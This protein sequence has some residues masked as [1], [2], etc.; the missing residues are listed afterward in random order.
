M[1]FFFLFSCT[2]HTALG[3][4]IKGNHIEYVIPYHSIRSID[5]CYW[6][7]NCVDARL[8]CIYMRN[9]IRERASERKGRYRWFHS[10]S[11]CFFFSSSVFRFLDHLTS[12]LDRLTACPNELLFYVRPPLLREDRKNA[13]IDGLQSIKLAQRKDH[14]RPTRTRRRCRRRHHHRRR[15]RHC[16]CHMQSTRFQNVITVIIIVDNNSL[17]F[18]ACG[19]LSHLNVELVSRQR[20][21]WRKFQRNDS[22]LYLSFLVYY[23][24]YEIFSAAAIHRVNRMHTNFS[25]LYKHSHSCRHWIDRV[26]RH[27]VGES[28]CFTVLRSIGD[29]S[30]MITLNFPITIIIADV[31]E[32]GGNS[33]CTTSTRWHRQKGNRDTTILFNADEMEVNH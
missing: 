19:C 20:M 21:K 10:N 15:R 1:Y 22:V 11:L 8:F 31:G 28:M 14:D 7:R 9:S 30:L 2:D 3:A 29:R 17:S 13:S 16:Y 26:A 23:V 25:P 24:H 33:G 12:H 18:G 32:G 4:K 27:L 5:I 6:P